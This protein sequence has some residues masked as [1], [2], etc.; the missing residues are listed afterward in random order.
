[1]FKTKNPLFLVPFRYGLVGALLNVLALLVLFYI[2]RHPLLLNPFLDTRLPLYGLFIFV[3]FKVYKEEYNNGIMHFWQGMIVGMLL[4]TIMALVSATFVYIYSEI[5]ATGF[6]SEYVR[7][8]TEQLVG[9][10]ETFIE[11][12]GEKTYYDTLEQLPKTESIHLA[13]DY[14]LKS[15]PIGLFLTL[16]LSILMRNK[17]STNTN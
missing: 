15:I 12:I 13:M 9:H 3:A 5:E 8:A 1:M 10:K 16:I 7:I 2:G 14:L 6:L 17:V 11:A 4:Y